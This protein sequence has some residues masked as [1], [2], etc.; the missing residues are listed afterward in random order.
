MVISRANQ[1]V[2]EVRVI[3]DTLIQ[4]LEADNESDWN[5]LGFH[6]FLYQYR[7][8]KQ[9]TTYYSKLRAEA[10]KR[11]KQQERQ[12]LRPI[13][14]A[15]KGLIDPQPPAHGAGRTVGARPGIYKGI[16]MRSQLEI[17]FA[18]ELDERG[19]KWVYECEALGEV[20]Y[21]VDFYLPDLAVWVEVKG[22]FDARDRQALPEISKFLKTERQQRLLVFTSSGNCFAVNPTSFR[23]VE[24]KNFWAELMK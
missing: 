23:E 18:S 3:S 13:D 4:L 5:F 22:R 24:R 16:Q 2:N 17:R 10:R 8:M 14:R 15:E 7:T 9:F 20:S 19:I 6:P 12:K 1:F 11:E 21:L